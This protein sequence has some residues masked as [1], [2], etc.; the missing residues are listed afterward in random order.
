MV[1]TVPPVISPK[2][3]PTCRQEHEAQFSILARTRRSG[4]CCRAAV[5]RCFVVEP[6]LQP[7]IGTGQTAAG[8][9]AALVAGRAAE[10]GTS[11]AGDGPDPLSQFHLLHLRR[12]SRRNA[13]S[14]T[15]PAGAAF[16]HRICCG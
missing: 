9:P 12:L 11:H 10:A 13:E 5:G 6:P 1:D 4:N 14:A 8:D 2:R 7:T 3:I 16:G 15:W